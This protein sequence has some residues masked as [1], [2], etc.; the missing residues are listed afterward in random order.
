MWF[1]PSAEH[2]KKVFEFLSLKLAPLLALSL[3]GFMIH[4][5]IPDSML[6]ILLVPVLKDKAG[7]V[8]CM[9]NYR[10]IALAS[11]LSNVVE[12]ILLDRVSGYLSSCDNQ[13]GFKQKHHAEQKQTK[14]SCST[15][16]HGTD[17]CMFALKEILDK[18]NRQNS[19][20][21][22]CFIDDSKAFDHVNHGNFYWYLHQTMRVRWGNVTSP[23]HVHF[24]CMWYR[25]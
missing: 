12:R 15:M 3:T 10:P 17:L 19:T 18:Y 11:I 25:L 22:M 13:F 2:L 9:D 8:S 1:G 16:L 23:F 6:S 7:W 20:I 4:G 14:A 5:I 24:K 21:F